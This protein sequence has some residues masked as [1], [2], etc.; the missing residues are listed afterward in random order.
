[1]AREL[2]RLHVDEGVAWSDLAVVVRRQGAHVGNLL[3]ALD[4]AQVPR[5]VPERG[6]SLGTAPSTHP[7]VLALRWLVAGGP[8]RDELVEPLLTSDVIGLSPAAARGLIRRARVEG[9]AAAEALDV[10]EGLDPAEADAVVAARETL[11][12][13]SLFAG[14]SVQDA[15]RVLWE[16]LPCSRRLVEAAGSEGADDRRDLDTVVTF[17]NAVAEA[18]EGGDTGVQG[19]LEALDAGEHGPGWTAWDRAGPDAVAVLTA[20]GTVGLEFDTVIVAGAAEGNFPSLGR[21]EPMFD[22]ASLERTPSRS[23]SVRARL[24]DERRLF[25]VV[26]GRAR[27]GVVLVCSDTHPDADELTLRTRFGGELGAT[28]LP[29]PGSPFDEPVSTREATALWRRQLADPSAEDWRRLAALDGLQALGAEPVHLVVPTRLDRDRATAPRAAAPQLLPAV[30][31]RELRAAARARR[32]ARA[33]PHGGLPGVGRQA[34]A[35]PDR[36]VREG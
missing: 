24:E 3:R 31:P 23:E 5:V 22:L 33:R 17:A 29:A 25:H 14:M 36:A 30:H 20:H 13:A 1:M 10:T 6:L 35:R 32:R 26:V 11:A 2:R 28:W 7:Y 27:R 15:F 18:S 19:F 9:R 34:R 4:D 16:E 21:P 8:E 12:K